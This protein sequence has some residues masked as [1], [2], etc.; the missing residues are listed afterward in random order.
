MATSQ[1]EQSDKAA[2]ARAGKNEW[3]YN[4]SQVDEF[5][6]NARSLYEED[7]PNLTQSEIHKVAFD[8]EKNGYDVSAVDAALRRLEAAVVDKLA[9]W[10]IEHEGR[11]EWNSQTEKLALTLIPRA[12]REDKKAFHDGRF[13]TPSYDKKQVDTF[14]RSAAN[15]INSALELGALSRTSHRHTSVTIE[16]YTLDNVAR[17]IFKQR[18]GSAGYDEAQVDAYIN[19]VSE[20]IARIEATERYDTAHTETGLQRFDFTMNNE[21]NSRPEAISPVEVSAL[22]TENQSFEVHDNEETRAAAAPVFNTTQSD[23]LS[24]NAQHDDSIPSLSP[25]TRTHTGDSK[26]D[27]KTEPAKQTES[28]AQ[29]DHGQQS[30]N[31]A[32]EHDNQEIP[33]S[34]APKHKPERGSTHKTTDID[35]STLMDTGSIKSVQFHLPDLGNDWNNGKKDE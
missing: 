19:R 1:S 17:I 33:Q 28:S 4:V 23:V 18:K 15:Y 31:Q 3:G 10:T 6:K 11:A 27:G 20:V 22:D 35:Y 32:E 30:A 9:E 29:T 13:M 24:D 12:K 16:K 21:L 34:F 5:L 14:I 7:E 26:S 25:L 8:L 2:I